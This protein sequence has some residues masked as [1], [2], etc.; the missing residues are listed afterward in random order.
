MSRIAVRCIRDP[1]TEVSIAIR[2]LESADHCCLTDPKMPLSPAAN[3]LSEK[4][5]GPNHESYLYISNGILH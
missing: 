5:R 4:A 2:S 1:S 3:H